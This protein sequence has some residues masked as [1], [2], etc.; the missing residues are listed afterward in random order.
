MA[1][2]HIAGFEDGRQKHHATDKYHVIFKIEDVEPCEYY[3]VVRFGDVR[4]TFKYLNE[5]YLLAQTATS[6]NA[7][8]PKPLR[9]AKE[10]AY[11][12]MTKTRRSSFDTRKY[13][14]NAIVAVFKSRIT[15][16]TQSVENECVAV[17]DDFESNPNQY[18]K[19]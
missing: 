7:P 1:R 12:I 3:V 2:A 18:L 5:A 10:D 9:K 6:R 16:F 14:F 13:D 19:G 11:Q 8:L 4:C 17:W 15:H